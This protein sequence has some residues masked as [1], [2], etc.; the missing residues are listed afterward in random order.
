MICQI[1]NPSDP[2]TLDTEDFDAAALCVRHV[3]REAYGLRSIVSAA[4]PEEL[5]TP[6]LFG[7]S[8]WARG[9]YLPSPAE[10]IAEHWLVM[11][12]ACESVWIGPVELRQILISAA[13]YM[14]PEAFLEFRQEQYDR[15]RTSLTRIGEAF[16]QYGAQ[17]R[18]IHGGP[19]HANV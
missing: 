4:D 16:W 8:E 7:W 13:Q 3:G 14:A 10:Y 15:Q 9:R 6:V 17:L 19:S 5:C 2:Y 1:I 18:R 12:Q 11:A